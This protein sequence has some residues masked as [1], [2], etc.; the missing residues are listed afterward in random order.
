MA[1]TYL[2]M[3]L[4]IYNVVTVIKCVNWI[5][6]LGN[7]L[8]AIVIILIVFLVIYNIVTMIKCVNAIRP[9]GNDLHAIEIIFIVFCIEH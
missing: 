8:H 4:F 1:Q 6:P 7:K 2:E 9:L 3:F 5:W